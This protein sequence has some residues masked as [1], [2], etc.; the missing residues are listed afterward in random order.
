MPC[1]ENGF[2]SSFSIAV[3]LDTPTSKLPRRHSYIRLERI[4]KSLIFF[5]QRGSEE[6]IFP[7]TK[8]E[9]VLYFLTKMMPRKQRQKKLG[10]VQ[11]ATIA[12]LAL[13][14]VLSLSNQEESLSG[15]MYSSPTAERQQSMT[16][17]RESAQEECKELIK[18]VG[19]NADSAGVD[20]K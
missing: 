14:V 1:L 13:F 2:A 11:F 7:G 19:K 16:K 8:P 17:W 4:S 20:K 6:T 3:V 12:V 5:Y 15:D 10:S 18:T 9:K